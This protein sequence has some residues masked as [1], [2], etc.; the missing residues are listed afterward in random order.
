MGFLGKFVGMIRIFQRTFGMPVSGGVVA[1][2]IV[3]G[4]RT[5]GVRG[6]FVLFGCSAVRIV[7]HA[8]HTASD[9]PIH[10]N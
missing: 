1:F 9:V 4:S 2:F 8:N 5:M 3:F 6:P 10:G 7:M